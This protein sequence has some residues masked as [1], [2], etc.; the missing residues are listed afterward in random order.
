MSTLDRILNNAA[1][2]MSAESIHMNTISSNLANSSNVGSDEASTYHAK[3]PQFQ[4]VQN[5]LPGFSEDEQPIGGV[6]VTKIGV[7]QTPLQKKYQPDNPLA[8]SD[9]YVYVT[10]VNPI[11]EMTNMIESSK[12]YQ[13]NVD[14]MNTAKNLILQTIGILNSK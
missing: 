2:G 3:V 1:S 10:N 14:M 6:T 11:E 12:A 13:A 4:E 7:D 9:G 8:N 5:A